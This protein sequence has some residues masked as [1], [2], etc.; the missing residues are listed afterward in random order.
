MRLDREKKEAKNYSIGFRVGMVDDQG[1]FMI[2][3]IQ[4]LK[5]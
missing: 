4:P 1:K 5:N 3:F 2:R